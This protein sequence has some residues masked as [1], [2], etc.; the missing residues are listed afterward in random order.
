[1]FRKCSLLPVELVSAS[2]SRGSQGDAQMRVSSLTSYKQSLQV[3]QPR[4]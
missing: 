2:I 1:M 4:M 3:Q